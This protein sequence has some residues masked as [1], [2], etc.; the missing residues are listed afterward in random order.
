MG[1]KI[2]VTALLALAIV[3]PVQAEKVSYGKALKA[4]V[5]TDKST[6]IVLADYGGTPID[7]LLYANDDPEFG[8]S[9][10]KLEEQ[11]VSELDMRDVK[12]LS[13]PYL[14]PIRTPSM[15]VGPISANEARDIPAGLLTK[16]LFIIGYDRVSL[17]WLEQN[18]EVLAQKQALGMMVNV[19]TP[20]QFAKVQSIAQGKVVIHPLSG[21]HLA[22]SIKLYHYPAFIDHGGLMR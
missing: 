3:I 1:K 11:P 21:E 10:M 5:L 22:S 13:N 18:L 12:A 4:K 17:S 16:P 20:E 14:Y 7:Q 15:S 2:Y 19:E 6:L 8:E 9:V